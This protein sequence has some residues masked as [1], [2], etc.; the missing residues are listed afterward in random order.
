MRFGGDEVS[1]AP[2]G[3]TDAVRFHFPKIGIADLE[4][5]G[6]NVEE[7]CFYKVFGWEERADLGFEVVLGGGYRHCRGEVFS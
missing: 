5:G 3:R 2:L 4:E 7:S 1:A 6:G